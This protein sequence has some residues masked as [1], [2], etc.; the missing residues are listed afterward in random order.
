MALQQ[1]VFLSINSAFECFH[2]KYDVTKTPVALYISKHVLTLPLYAEL[3]L[4]DV[5]RICDI[6][7]KCKY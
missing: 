1:E 2:G 4:E 7:L 5:D 3:A 6:I